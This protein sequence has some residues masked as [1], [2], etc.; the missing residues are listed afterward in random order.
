MSTSSGLR[1]GVLLFLAGS[2]VG[3]GLLLTSAPL[4]TFYVAPVLIAPFVVH[5][6]R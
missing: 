6:L 1:L 2:A 4:W 3:A 5:R